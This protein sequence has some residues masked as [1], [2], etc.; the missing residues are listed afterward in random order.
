MKIF[1]F[2]DT[3]LFAQRVILSIVYANDIPNGI[4]NWK[5]VINIMVSILIFFVWIQQRKD[6]VQT[7]LSQSNQAANRIN[8]KTFFQV[9]IENL[10]NAFFSHDIF[11][12]HAI[13]IV[14]FRVFKYM[15]K[16]RWAEP[17]YWYPIKRSGNFL[18]VLCC[19]YLTW[20]HHLSGMQI[21]TK[22]F[23]CQM[24]RNPTHMMICAGVIFIELSNSAIV[25]QFNGWSHSHLEWKG[26][27][28][29]KSQVGSN[30]SNS[31]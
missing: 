19:L 4:I 2:P 13:S 25:L 22:L 3:F 10:D 1:L 7:I 14:E 20:S 9:A 8:P 12:N 24:R 15:H 5:I 31:R 17:K 16:L 30:F 21:I 11:L 26:R 23:S 29:F 6:I 28:L 18:V 27:I